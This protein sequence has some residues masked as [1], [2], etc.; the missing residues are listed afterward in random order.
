MI[1]DAEGSIDVIPVA[2]GG[3][4]RK[5][6]VVSG[7]TIIVE[8]TLER[9]FV[10]FTAS[11]QTFQNI[12]PEVGQTPTL[13]ANKS[14]QLVGEGM[15]TN[16]LLADGV[17]PEVELEG[18]TLANL[19]SEK[20]SSKMT[21]NKAEN[22]IKGG[23]NNT[24][25][26]ED[27][28]VV[29]Q[30][31]L[32]GLT[33]VNIMPET[34][35]TPLISNNDSQFQ[36]NKGLDEAIILDNDKMLSSKIYGETI[37]NCMNYENN[38]TPLLTLDMI[39]PSK[40]I[41]TI[42]TE[43][44][45]DYE[46]N[47][48]IQ[49]GGEIKSA[50]LKG[51]TLMN[52][53]KKLTPENHGDNKE[54]GVQGNSNPTHTWN[55]NGSIT[56]TST[57][58]GSMVLNYYNLTLFKPN[59]EYTLFV[60][61]GWNGVG[62]TPHLSKISTN[63]IPLNNG[64][65]I[66]KFT[67]ASDLT[68]QN[69]SL[70]LGYI[71]TVA[72]GCEY[73]FNNIIVLEGDWTND[74]NIPF[75]EGMQSVK[76]PVLTTTGKNLFDVSRHGSL[77][78]QPNGDI[79]LNSAAWGTYDVKYILKPNTQYTLTILGDG[80]KC[81]MAIF[82]DGSSESSNV[83]TSYTRTFSTNSNGEVTIGIYANTDKYVG[84]S[85]KSISIEEGTVST[86]YE[87]HKSNIL[88][89]NE[90]VR[91]SNVCDVKDELN[92]LTG[93]LTQRTGEVVLNGSEDW[94]QSAHA[95]SILFYTPLNNLARK[96]DYLNSISCDKLVV[97]SDEQY[98]YNSTS[99]IGI[100]AYADWSDGYPNENWIY[101]KYADSKGSVEK[102]KQWLSQNPITVQYEL[103][104][105]S[106]KTVDLKCVNQDD[107]LID[108]CHMFASGYISVSSDELAPT[109]EYILPTTNYFELDGLKSGTEYTLRFDGEL[110]SATLGGSTINTVND[111]VV[112]TSA[113]DNS[114]C[115]DGD[116]SNVSNIMLL[117]GNHVGKN[118][119]YFTGMRSVEAI[120]VETTS[121]IEQPLFGRGGRK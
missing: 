67:T 80:T 36:I 17:M 27:G 85:R 18:F 91:L 83:D 11:G 109:L 120:E 5:N 115:L 74:G 64:L 108:E 4:D 51:R 90:E 14:Q 72:V 22:D 75:F 117:E 87:P 97:Y 48:K 100:S 29:S 16:I 95:N 46:K 78:P 47:I 105:E 37:K 10:N 76:M 15:P 73:T 88:T 7:E 65:N 114:L 9:E 13:I 77:T 20:R 71:G 50:I 119:P 49:D 92:L 28:G 103:A 113:T 55:S 40:S 110:T 69:M 118:I 30:L 6:A 62:V 81:W 38:K 58:K 94:T 101:V 26:V 8:Q 54:W 32:D 107:E 57:I 39:N 98:L 1:D 93:E 3:F 106:V 61:V 84:Y 121:K 112:A 86:P 23:L 96:L 21:C 25:I 52:L 43:L 12:V 44:Y 99:P 41:E 2:W 45:E 42:E 82:V 34:G 19:A 111:T 24:F 60:S 66:V 33:L 68:V 53:V 35:K 31:E 79:Q 56:I 116:V 104:V 102:L 89:V 70:R 63:D 59:T